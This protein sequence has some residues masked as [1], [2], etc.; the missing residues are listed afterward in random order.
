MEFYHWMEQ[1]G[2]NLLE[3]AGIIGSLAFTATALHRDARSRRLENLLTLTGSHREIWKEPLRDPHLR[4]ILVREV[5]LTAEPVTAEEAIFVKL[6]VQHLHVVHH[7]LE[8]RLTVNAEG[9]RRDV[10]QFFALP[11]PLAVWNRIKA[12]QN[13]RFVAFVEACRSGK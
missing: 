10:R 13:A 1:Y 11:V 12:L 2:F 9:L 4:R 7:A 3:A 6:V 5:D 8:S